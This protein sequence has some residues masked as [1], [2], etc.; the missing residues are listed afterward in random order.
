MIGKIPVFLKVTLAILIIMSLTPLMHYP[1]LAKKKKIRHK[2]ENVRKEAI[3]LIR[4]NSESVSELAGLE[5]V[6]GDSLNTMQ[7]DYEIGEYGEDIEELESEDDVTVDLETLK[8]LWLSY[9]TDTEDEYL[10]SGISKSEIMNEVLEWL[11]TRYKF[12]G[13]SN[14]GIDCSA[15]VR[16]LFL[17]SAQIMIPRTAREQYTIGADIKRKNLEFG[18]L[19]FFHTRKRVYVSH[20]GIYLGDNLFAHASSKYGVTVSS[21]ESTYYNKRFIGAKRLSVGDLRRYSVN[22]DKFDKSSM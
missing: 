12:G 2:K 22:S 3:K 11:G 8:S 7:N 19:V 6:L 5:P 4:E 9:V 15:F 10:A 20:V 14:D 16:H 21:L 18:D 17:K 1:A 13:S